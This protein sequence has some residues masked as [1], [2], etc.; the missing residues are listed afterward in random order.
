M[1]PKN[2]AVESRAKKLTDLEPGW[3][4]LRDYCEQELRYGEI[5]V[6]I[7]NG[8]PVAADYIKKKIKFT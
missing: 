7:Q 3:V 8:Q 4:R 6:K 2:I 5:K 1:E